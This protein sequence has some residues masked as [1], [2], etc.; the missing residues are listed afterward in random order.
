APMT[1]LIEPIDAIARRKQRDVLKVSFQPQAQEL[2]EAA[3]QRVIDFLTAHGVAWQACGDVADEGV[4][5]SYA[6]QIYIDLPYEP[7]NPRC[8]EILDFFEHPDGSMKDPAVALWLLRLASAMRNAHHD[9]PG[10]WD[11]WAERF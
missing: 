9:E 1:L 8:R 5:A 10:F 4:M 7:Q 3:R 11:R 2:R 6:G